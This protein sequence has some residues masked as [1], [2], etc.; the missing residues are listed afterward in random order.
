ME[1]RHKIKSIVPGS[2]AEELSLSP[3]DELLRING[4]KIADIFDYHYLVND[5]FLTQ[6][7]RAHV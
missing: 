3:G 1:N 2:I 5:E 4:K 7:G 6:I